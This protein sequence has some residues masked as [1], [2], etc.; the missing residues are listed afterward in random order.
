MSG[1]KSM[2]IF[3]FFK[4]HLWVPVL[5][6]PSTPC[7]AQE[8]HLEVTPG[9]TGDTAMPC[10]AVGRENEQITDLQIPR[11][12]QNHFSWERAQGPVSPAMNLSVPSALGAALPP[13]QDTAFL[14][15]QRITALCWEQVQLHTSVVQS[16]AT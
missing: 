2:E 14:S 3:F 4:L 10:T 15:D 12:S 13:Q 6:L 5:L 16:M 9:S 11:E 8:G 1:I 7:S